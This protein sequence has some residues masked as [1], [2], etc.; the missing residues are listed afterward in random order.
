MAKPFLKR[1]TK[2]FFIILNILVSAL[3]LAGANTQY[4]HPSLWWFVGL[5]AL[6]LPYLILLLI[7]FFVSWLLTK[8][9][10]LLLPAITLAFGWNA[11]Q[12]IIPFNYSSKFK[13]E[14]DTNTLRIMSWN[15]ELFDI[16]EHKTHPEVKQKM[17]E[18]INQYKPDIACFQEMVGGDYDRVIN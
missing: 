1:V 12:N 16:Q 17:L 7:I 4:F 18:L 14:K 15:V 13:V 9:A 6:S 8:S 5:L 11:I 10:W 2:T 3:F